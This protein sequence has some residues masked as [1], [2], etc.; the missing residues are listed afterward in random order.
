MFVHFRLANR[1]IRYGLLMDGIARLSS[2]PNT[3]KQ[4]D[5][6]LSKTA[7]GEG[8]LMSSGQT[9]PQ[10]SPVSNLFRVPFEMYIFTLQ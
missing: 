1:D 9:K 10:L 5:T 8:M 6:L 3:C 2:F 4:N 7:Q